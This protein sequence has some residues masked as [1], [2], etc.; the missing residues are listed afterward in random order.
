M[1]F[2]PNLRL[3]LWSANR[4]AA[5]LGDLIAGAD[6]VLTSVEEARVVT[7]RDNRVDAAKWLLDNGSRLVVVKDGARGAWAT[8]G[9]GEWTVPAR[10]VTVLDPVGA[11]DAFDAGFLSGWLDDLLVPDCLVRAAAAGASSVQSLGDLDGLPYRTD[12]PA[13]TDESDVDR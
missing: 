8:D 4:A 13:L 10:P 2:D 1:S 9:T 6:I 7:G 12:L 3:R 11:G 5:V